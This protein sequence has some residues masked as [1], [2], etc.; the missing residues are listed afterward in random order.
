MQ[1]GAVRG[2]YTSTCENVST[3]CRHAMCHLCFALEIFTK[4]WLLSCTCLHRRD[5]STRCKEG[6]ISASNG[7]CRRTGVAGKTTG[8]LCVYVRHELHPKGRTMAFDRAGK[9]R[10]AVKP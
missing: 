3:L 1:G 2:I 10:V 4:F 5:V 6:K 9:L 8:Q 7:E